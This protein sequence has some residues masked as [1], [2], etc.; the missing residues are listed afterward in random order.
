MTYIEN[1]VPQIWRHSQKKV[2]EC[3]VVNK[4]NV[5]FALRQYLISAS[6]CVRK[7]TYFKL[8][9]GYSF[10]RLG[11]VAGSYQ[12]LIRAGLFLLH[13]IR[14]QILRHMNTKTSSNEATLRQIISFQQTE[15]AS[16]RETLTT[17]LNKG[18]SKHPAPVLNGKCIAFTPEYGKEVSCG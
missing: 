2:K 17:L 18:Y 4:C 1:N 14:Y 3:L 5:I 10:V 8:M 13:S 16:L 9:P 11:T 7:H 15:I 6:E 12:R